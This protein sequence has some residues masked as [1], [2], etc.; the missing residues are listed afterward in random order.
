MPRSSRSIPVLVLAL[1]A[2]PV[3]LLAR[4]PA[5]AASPNDASPSPTASTSPS[6]ALAAP[7]AQN[8]GTQAITLSAPAAEAVTFTEETVALPTGGFSGTIGALPTSLSFSYA[9]GATLS[10]PLR[11]GDGTLA[12]T[13]AT[14]RIPFQ[15]YE[16]AA[17][18]ATDSALVWR[19]TAD[20]AR[21]VRLWAW[22]R[23]SSA[24]EAVAS[25]R[26]VAE[27]QLS[28]RGQAKPEFVDNGMVHLLV[29]GEDPFAD[30]LTKPVDSAFADPSSYDFSIAHFSDTQYLTEGAVERRTAAERA[31]WRKAY[32]EIP[33]WI[34]AN[35]ATRKIAYTAHTGDVIEDW[36]STAYPDEAAAKANARAQFAV[37]SANQKI[38]DDA[39]LVNAILPGNHDTRAGTDTGA[40]ALFNDYFGTQR[41]QALESGSQWQAEN[42][43]YHPWKAGDNSNHYDLFSAG[44]LDFVA[45]HLGYGVSPDEI[46]WAN[47]VLTRYADRNAI[48]FTHAFNKASFAADGRSADYSN[49]GTRLEE[50]VIASH[51]NVALVLAGHEHGV[52]IAV[53]K[54]LG[55]SGNNV[56]ELLADYQFYQVKAAEVGLAG[57]GGHSAADQLRFGASFLQLLQ[58]NVAK[59]EVSIDTFSPLLNNFNASEYD[60]QHRYNGQED[61]TTVPVQLTTRKTSFSTDTIAVTTTADTIGSTTS[62]ASSLSWTGLTSG[63]V[64]GW[65]AATSQGDVLGSGLF[66]VPAGH[67]NTA[68]PSLDVPAA[69]SEVGKAFDATAGLTGGAASLTVLGGIDTNQVGTQQLGYLA[70]DAD[71]NQTLAVRQVQVSEAEAAEAPDRG[72]PQISVLLASTRQGIATTAF[73]SVKASG[74]LVEGG[75]V[76]LTLD[77]HR[78]TTAALSGGQVQLRLPA[79]LSPGGHVLQTAYSGDEV[80]EAARIESTFTVAARAQR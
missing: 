31:V 21:L 75:E 61:D 35:A 48:L 8:Q 20:P 53:K 73:V 79:E 59:G 74:H 9:R 67:G 38:L 12:A 28:L 63:E 72:Y 26:G 25:G 3:A 22:N 66:T 44:G 60:N 51:P 33:R 17:A 32:T 7:S 2:A 71:S 37:A 39:G 55:R 57:V 18:S 50:Q 36:F 27:G 41:Y 13:V 54:N 1:L 58:F 47:R 65:R 6:T 11:P 78:Y 80:T 56:T 10:D 43:S 42:A 34:A 5:N 30:D 70:T 23:A 19:G 14:G 49:D 62:T 76:T 64:R 77:G 40:G 24:W 29:T 4:T 69:S 45:V 16:I 68:A 15:R 46:A 52:S